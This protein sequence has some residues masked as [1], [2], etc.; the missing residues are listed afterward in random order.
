MG[1]GIRD[2]GAIAEGLRLGD[3]DRRRAADQE[4]EKEFRDSERQHMVE[5]RGIT[6]QRQDDEH[7][8][9]QEQRDFAK[10]IESDLRQF[11]A[12]NGANYQGIIDTYNN[13]FPDGHKMAAERN[14]DGTFKVSYIGQDGKAQVL[15]ENMSFDEFGQQTLSL[16]DP[17]AYLE[18]RR[19]ANAPMK[20]RY[21]QNADGQ[22]LD[23]VTGNTKP[24]AGGGAGGEKLTK[25][26]KEFR[27]QANSAWGSQLGDNFSFS[28]KDA[29]Y[30]SQTASLAFQIY[31]KMPEGQKSTTKAHELALKQIRSGKARKEHQGNIPGA[32]S[33]FDMN[34][35]E[36]AQAAEYLNTMFGPDNDPQEIRQFMAGGGISSPSEQDKV[37]AKMGATTGAKG[38]P[39][40]NAPA[41]SGQLTLPQGVKAD[42]AIAQAK[43]AIQKNPAAKA[44]VVERMKSWGFTDAMLKE[45][46]L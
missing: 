39:T 3:E 38:L 33:V 1:L 32:T 41:A 46:G 30:A 22:V 4:S 12:S 19:A 43:S 37:L 27:I 40:N 8:F 11:V 26:E 13:K 7:A 23:T 36:V 6:E 29:E 10:Q 24:G 45:A 25:I 35:N 9:Q 5:R 14:Q 44:K 17:K 2:F 28:G 15:K 34:E 20:G 18:A 16:L 42:Q 31:Q 21:S